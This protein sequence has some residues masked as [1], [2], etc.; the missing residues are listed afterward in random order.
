MS[1]SGCLGDCLVDALNNDQVASHCFRYLY[2]IPALQ[3]VYL[4][5]SLDEEVFLIACHVVF[6]HYFEPVSLLDGPRYDSA[7][8]EEGFVVSCMIEFDDIEQQRTITL[9]SSC[10]LLEF[11][12]SPIV[13]INKSLRALVRS[14]YV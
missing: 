5:C 9:A 4:A 10:Y 6:S 14:L 13:S 1:N 7:K 12:I 11:A 8:G 2:A 3:K